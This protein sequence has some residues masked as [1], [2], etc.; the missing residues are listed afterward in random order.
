M[1]SKIKRFINISLF[2]LSIIF[3]SGCKHGERLNKEKKL[4]ALSIYGITQNIEDGNS[5]FELDKKYENIKAEDI[6]V[7]FTNVSNPLP[8][9]MEPSFI[10]VKEQSVTF[11]VF[12]AE[13]S[14]LKFSVNI[15]VKH[16][17]GGQTHV[18]NGDLQIWI[19]LTSSDKNEA[20]EALPDPEKINNYIFEADYNFEEYDLPQIWVLYKKEPASKVKSSDLRFSAS[21]DGKMPLL[22]YEKF[23]QQ[24]RELKIPL[25][26]TSSSENKIYNLIIKTKKAPESEN[27]NLKNI[28]FNGKEGIIEGRNIICNSVFAVGSYIDVKTI[29]EH[30][31]A[32]CK[33]NGGSPVIISNSGAAFSIIVTPEKTDGIRKTYNVILDAPANKAVT[34]IKHLNTDPLNPPEL[35]ALLPAKI[36][37]NG[38]ERSVTVPLYTASENAFFHFEHLSSLEIESIHILKN[39][40]WI[41]LDG[42]SSSRKILTL[43]EGILPIPPSTAHSL[44]LKILFKDKSYDSLTVKFKKPQTLKPLV[45]LGLYI[46]DTE[47]TNAQILS[48]FDGSKPLF[49]AKGP[50]IYIDVIT[51][52]ALSVTVNGV[53]YNSVYSGFLSYGLSFPIEMPDV[54]NEKDISVLLECEYAEN[55]NL[56]FKL[57]RLEGTVKLNLYPAINGY[58]VGKD[59][60]DKFSTGEKPVVKIIGDKMIFTLDTK[61]TELEEVLVNTKPAEIKTLTDSSTG[62]KFWRV[63]FTMEGFKTEEEREITI[64]INP[65]DKTQYESLTWSFK[66]R[67]IS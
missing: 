14:P 35:S 7:Y 62:E 45:I 59:L 61:Q 11:K 49:S 15:T 2:I 27:A 8:V 37:T 40:K 60:L 39:N 56:Q 21:A 16:K 41:R 38:E 3:Y 66:V 20:P 67:R 63:K 5:E 24:N 17:T 36:E 55:A 12:E 43:R 30:S 25:Y 32:V 46:N 31:K 48:Y 47:I 65:K 42:Y 52:E 22:L 10:L 28:T 64:L 53:K 58:N 34:G 51:K 19:P 29:T 33:I 44:K 1:K 23:P 9:R 57:K 26:V 6:K 54:N 18:H 4:Y 13:G 50:K